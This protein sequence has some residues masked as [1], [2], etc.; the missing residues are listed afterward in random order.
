MILNP[1]TKKFEL[2]LSKKQLQLVI[3]EIEERHKID[4]PKAGWY[5]KKHLTIYKKQLAKC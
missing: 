4:I 1:N 3:A 2:I 5:D